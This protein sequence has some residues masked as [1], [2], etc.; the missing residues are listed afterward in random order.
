MGDEINDLQLCMNGMFTPEREPHPVVA[1]IR[2]LMQPVVSTPVEASASAECVRVEVMED[3]HVGGLRLPVNSRHVFSALEHLKWSWTKTSN[4]R[5]SN[6][7]STL[8]SVE[9]S[10]CKL[11]V[12]LGSMPVRITYIARYECAKR[13]VIMYMYHRK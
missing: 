9:E 12:A 10:K 3:Y 6:Q 5:R 7:K 11:N 13:W 4:R 2:C 8:I 1:E